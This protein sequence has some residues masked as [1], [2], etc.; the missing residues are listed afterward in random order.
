MA[1]RV[2]RGGCL[3]G[4][5]SF[6]AEEPLRHV[7]ACHC[8]QCRRTSGHFWAATSVPLGRFRL[9]RESAALRWF[10]SS[11]AATRGFCSTCG[12][13]L[14]WKPEGE[15]R[16]AIAAGAL[17]GPTGLALST[18][19]HTEG[20]GDYYAPEGPPLHYRLPPEQVMAELRAADLDVALSP[21][22]NSRQY[23]VLAT[24]P[25]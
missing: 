11:P 2:H 7:I 16:I 10:R 22:A 8:S 4:S 23:A 12:A 14:F 3:C 19:I 24:R 21:Y 15:P 25:R 6:E 5:V 17:D 9:T 13:S 1:D 20:A 18:H